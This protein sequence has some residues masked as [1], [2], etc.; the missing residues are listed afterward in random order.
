MSRPSASGDLVAAI[1]RA[2]HLISLYL[3]RELAEV[4]VTQAEAHVLLRLARG[5]AT[6]PNDLHRLFG[7][8]R[9]TLTSVLDRLESRGL[10]V[11]TTNP[12]DRRSFLISLTRVGTV[13]ARQVAAVVAALEQAV[14]TA[15]TADAR[16][17]FVDVLQ[18]VHAEVERG[19]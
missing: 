4:A 16:Q 1:E 9:S 10:V 6:S 19:R 18:A 11:R 7:H 17:G 13:A 5:G 12:T 3:D 2:S 15:T 14:D 8:K